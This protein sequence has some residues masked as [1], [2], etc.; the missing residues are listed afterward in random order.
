MLLGPRAHAR[1][2]A[3]THTHTG[4]HTHT[5]AQR[6]HANKH[7]RK[8]AHTQ[9]CTQVC[10]NVHLGHISAVL[11]RSTDRNSPH[12]P[13]TEGHRVQRAPSSAAFRRWLSACLAR[14]A[15]RDTPKSWES[16]LAGEGKQG[17]GEGG[18]ERKSE[19][20]REREKKREE[21]EREGGGRKCDR[22]EKIAL[23]LRVLEDHAPILLLGCGDWPF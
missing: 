2:H 15:R 13:P 16:A 17:K 8:Q 22:K 10:D 7:T 18:I 9:A 1:T 19:R 6:T 20:E 21:R 4:T 11:N 12:V 5:H 23:L 14:Q 3:R